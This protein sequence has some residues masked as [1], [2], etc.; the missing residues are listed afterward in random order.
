MRGP[1]GWTLH[2]QGAD[3]EV[4]RERENLMSPWGMGFRDS[5]A[6]GPVHIE[7]DVPVGHGVHMS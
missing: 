5:E 1:S 4:A 6:L 2:V 3:R 7:F